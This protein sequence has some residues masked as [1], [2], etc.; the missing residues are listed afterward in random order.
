MK[1]LH[2]T[3]ELLE[4]LHIGT[5]TGMGDIDALQVRDR[6]DSPVLPSSH[7]KGLLLQTAREL[8]ALQPQALSQTDIDTL[9]GRPGSGQGC[10]QLTSAYLKTDPNSD[11]LDTLV[12][13]STRIDPEKG[14]AQD[15]S[16]RQVE[17]IAAGS[18]FTLQAFLPAKHETLLKT[19]IGHCARL[20][21]GR[22]RGYGLV[23]WQLKNPDTGTQKTLQIPHKAPAYPQRLRLLLR[24]LDPV[25]LA[26]TGHPGNL[27]GSDAFIRGRSL[28]GSFAAACIALGQPAWAQT[29]LQPE[30]AWADALPLPTLK[31]KLGAKDLQ[32]CEVLPIA[33]SIGTPK[34]TATQTSLPW[35]ALQQE[36]QLLGAR[37]EINQI[38]TPKNEQQA[39]K[40]K[41]PAANEYLF[42]LSP[43]HPWTRYTPQMQERLRT[44]VARLG[45]QDDQALFTNEEIAEHTWFLADLVVTNAAQAK[46]LGQLVQEIDQQWLRVGRGGKPLELK[47]AKWLDVKPCETPTDNKT[48]SFTLLLLSDLI[49]RDA[50]GNFHDRITAQALCQL[51][52]LPE[53]SHISIE[54]NHS[55]G[56]NLYGFNALT[57]LPRMAQRGIKAGSI[58]SISG[59]DAAKLR[60]ALAGKHFL[61]ESPEEGFGRFILDLPLH[62]DTTQAQAPTTPR[63]SFSRRHEELCVQARDFSQQYAS[64]IAKPSASQWGDFRNQVQAAR[65]RTELMAVF[66]RI[67]EAALKQGGKAW[68]GLAGGKSQALRKEV[69]KLSLPD[70]QD[71]LDYFVRWQRVQQNRK[72]D[73]KEHQA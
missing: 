43:D 10:V 66:A 13:G 44:S 19:I 2:L 73:K 36:A 22:N 12:W 65:N 41:R 59:A 42:R 60:T 54:K 40:L 14:N 63:S 34:A 68:E 4:D 67:D 5:G 56:C 38:D 27:I 39:E 48:G 55:E 24:N 46:T 11:A 72:Q 70:A 23:Q 64:A 3:I 31:N 47:A 26:Q 9:F 35:W 52:G 1:K 50:L 61:G 28:R 69:G 45:E 25:C 33:L 71:L 53:N 17:Y 51:T 62:P 18:S 15:T 58:A 20:G 32:T 8:M 37:G 7:I 16:L 30:L 29:L 49:A 21:S 6:N 57:G